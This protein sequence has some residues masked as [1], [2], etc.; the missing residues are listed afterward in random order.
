MKILKLLF[1]MGVALGIY[2]C[3]YTQLPPQ[4]LAPE[5]AQLDPTFAVATLA[6]LGSFEF[7]AAPA[8]TRNAALRHRSAALARAGKIDMT[9]L[10]RAINDCDSARKKLDAALDADRQ[11]NTAGAQQ[12]LSEAVSIINSAEVSLNA[13][14]K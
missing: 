5:Q 7:V 3:A 11:H 13:G 4:P 8:F 10:Q 2:A 9:T 12:L 14:V 6:P 1:I